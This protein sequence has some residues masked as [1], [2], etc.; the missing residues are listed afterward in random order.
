MV[1][2]VYGVKNLYDCSENVDYDEFI[3]NVH[4]FLT[5]HGDKIQALSWNPRETAESIPSF[6]ELY[7]IFR[8]ILKNLKSPNVTSKAYWLRQNWIANLISR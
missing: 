7:V 3:T 8:L 6:L 2:V 5:R 4:S 1:E